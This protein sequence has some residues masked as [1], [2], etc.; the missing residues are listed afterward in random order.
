MNAR[1]DILIKIGSMEALPSS[2]AK[3][4]NMLNDPDVDMGEVVALIEYDP[5]LTANVLKLANSSAFGVEGGV[6]SLKEATV[7][8][9]STNLLQMLISS[10]MA[11]VLKRPVRG[12]DLPPS[13]LWRHSVCV[14]LCVRILEETLNLTLPDHAFT[15]ALLHDVGKIALAEFVEDDVDGIIAETTREGCSLCEAERKLLGIDHAEAGAFL[16]KTWRLPF[17]LE[18]AARWHHDPEKSEVDADV[19]EMVHVAN[20][21]TILTGLGVGVEGLSCHLS[22]RIV[23][24]HSLG[25]NLVERILARMQSDF[26]EVRQIFEEK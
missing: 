1:D 9:G 8:I 12:Y 21:L 25:I 20:A 13:E 26:E 18:N 22:E 17:E 2:V 15:S 11:D 19:V 14:G 10:T 16:L 3:A 24:K 4:I 5:T 7:R 6:K 23:A